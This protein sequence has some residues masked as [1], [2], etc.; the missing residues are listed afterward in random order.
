MNYF[1]E[2]TLN[3]QTYFRDDLVGLINKRI[4]E[5]D[6]SDFKKSLY[7]FINEWISDTKRLLLKH[8]ELPA[9]QNN[10]IQK[11]AV[12]KQCT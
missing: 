2:L 10:Y 3:S 6:I 11:R 1:D 7:N 4:D 8:P 5:H 9:P 12:Y